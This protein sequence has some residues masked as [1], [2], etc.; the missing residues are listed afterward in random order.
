M[1]RQIKAM[2]LNHVYI[3]LKTLILTRSADTEYAQYLV[4][5]LLQYA[6]STRLCTGTFCHT[7][8]REI[9]VV[10]PSHAYCTHVY[11]NTRSK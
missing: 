8:R 10:A 4:C 9:S 1:L 11:N 7:G 5:A 2:N 3:Q 6:A